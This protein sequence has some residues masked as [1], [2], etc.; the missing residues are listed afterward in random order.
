MATVKGNAFLFSQAKHNALLANLL[1]AQDFLF[2]M[3][4]RQSLTI[5][6]ALLRA[7]RLNQEGMCP[8][9][10]SDV[11]LAVPICA[12]MHR[13]LSGQCPVRNLVMSIACLAKGA[14]YKF[15]L[16]GALLVRKW[17]VLPAQHHLVQRRALLDGELVGR[18]MLRMEAEELA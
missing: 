17:R 15:I 2:G 5:P 7:V 10:Q 14:T 6:A 18:Y 11:R 12:I 8:G 4:I 3:P 1:R 9:A 13:L 16:M